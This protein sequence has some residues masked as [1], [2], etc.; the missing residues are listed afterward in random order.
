MQSSYSNLSMV[1]DW[2]KADPDVFTTNTS[3]PG[4][5]NVDPDEAKR[6]AIVSMMDL[7]ADSVSVRC[8]FRAL[9]S[10]NALGIAYAE[11]DSVS[12]PSVLYSIG[13]WS[14]WLRPAKVNILL[15]K[16]RWRREGHSSIFVPPRPAIKQ[17]S[18]GRLAQ[19]E[20][21]GRHID[22]DVEDSKTVLA[23]SDL[24]GILLRQVQCWS[25]AVART[26]PRV[27]ALFLLSRQIPEKQEERKGKRPLFNCDEDMVSG[28]ALKP[29]V[30]GVS[31]GKM[32]KT[33]DSDCN[34]PIACTIDTGAH[35][36]I[37]ATTSQSLRSCNRPRPGMRV[38]VQNEGNSLPSSGICNASL[39]LCSGA[40]YR[41]P[42]FLEKLRSNARTHVD[43]NENSRPKQSPFFIPCALVTSKD[44]L[45][46]ILRR[47]P[48]IKHHTIKDNFHP[49]IVMI[50][51][52]NCWVKI[53]HPN[54]ILRSGTTSSNASSDV[55]KTDFRN[56]SWS[57]LV[58][59]GNAFGESL[60]M[61]P[62]TSSP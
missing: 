26:I 2:T 16:L 25:N 39:I 6:S 31:H 3:K 7:G 54:L 42:Q 4:W 27:Q 48:G 19:F 47:L 18:F 53:L 15:L 62:S 52:M 11:V 43:K 61:R 59:A 14:K 40:S 17:P 5:C 29:V 38:A 23:S 30:F 36:L 8:L 45:L 24:P 49:V 21:R 33:Q 57:L 55:E 12:A 60:P 20:T 50:I 46:E 51:G 1:S 9:V 35:N 13:D 32:M 41:Y 58:F 10:I 28:H 44:G 37:N 22:E 56:P 34:Q